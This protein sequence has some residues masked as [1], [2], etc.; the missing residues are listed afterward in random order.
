M[1]ADDNCTVT[2]SDKILC[3]EDILPK[4]INATSLTLRNC[5]SAGWRLVSKAIASIESLRTLT[6]QHCS[7]GDELWREFRDYPSKL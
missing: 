6:I 3:F 5:T 2:I 7:I 4:H 1:I